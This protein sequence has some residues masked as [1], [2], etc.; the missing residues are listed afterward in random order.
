MGSIGR[1]ITAMVT[2]FNALGDV[3]FG[4]E[5]PRMD[6]A[7]AMLRSGQRE[8]VDRFIERCIEVYPKQRVHFGGWVA[9]QEEKW[10][11]RGAARSR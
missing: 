10:A 5:G 4:I 2:P 1:L 9:D 11:K 3:D 7:Y 6:L 8:A